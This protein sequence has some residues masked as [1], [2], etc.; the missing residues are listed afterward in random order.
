FLPGAWDDLVG[1]GRGEKDRT[2]TVQSRAFRSG[3]YGSFPLRTAEE[4]PG[5]RLDVQERRYGHGTA[6]SATMVV[7]AA[8]MGLTSATNSGLERVSVVR[9]PLGVVEVF[10]TLEWP[11]GR[12]NP[13]WSHNPRCGAT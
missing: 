5:R 8:G 10:R 12:G 3:R 13:P 6:G 7:A 11:S 2:T 9:L 4:T 1:P